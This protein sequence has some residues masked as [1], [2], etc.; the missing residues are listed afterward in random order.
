M[1][2][3]S[4]RLLPTGECWCGCGEVTRIGSFF[5]PGHDRIAETAVITVEYGGVPKFLDSH[6][7]GHGGKNPKQAL[8]EL[9]DRQNQVK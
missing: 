9:R 5:K 8:Q 2:G 1:M 6:G 7:Y 3:P 4:K